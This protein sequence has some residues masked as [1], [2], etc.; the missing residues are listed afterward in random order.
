MEPM[1]RSQRNLLIAISVGLLS[2]LWPIPGVI[3]AALVFR[4]GIHSSA[5]TAYLVLAYL[6]NFVLFAAVTYAIAANVSRQPRKAP[7]KPTGP[8]KG[9][10]YTESELEDFRRRGL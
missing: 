8:E 2:D 7:P 4:E 1:K 6:L 9:I 10:I 3:L 5:P